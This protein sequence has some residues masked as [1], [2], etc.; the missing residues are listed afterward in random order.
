MGG[1][2][3]EEQVIPRPIMFHAYTYHAHERRI[4]P[5]A[6]EVP[7]CEA[8]YGLGVVANRSQQI[9]YVHTGM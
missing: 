6:R 1:A 4:L 9:L 5:S 3:I 8:A 7:Y 2:E